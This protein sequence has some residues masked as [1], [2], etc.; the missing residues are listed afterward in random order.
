M[1][2]VETHA[3]HSPFAQLISKLSS[4]RQ[5]WAW[6]A[7]RTQR[8]RRDSACSMGAGGGEGGRGEVVNKAVVAGLLG[9]QL[10]SLPLGVVSR[11]PRGAALPRLD[12]VSAAAEVTAPQATEEEKFGK[13]SIQ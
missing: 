9:L 6:A 10:L 5:H 7:G 2:H 1:G 13:L 12:V 8:G 3:Q 11:Q 4:R